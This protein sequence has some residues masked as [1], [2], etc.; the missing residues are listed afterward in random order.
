MSDK[1]EPEAEPLLFWDFQNTMSDRGVSVAVGIPSAAGAGCV[2][3]RLAIA[4]ERH[5]THT[6]IHSCRFIHSCSCSACSASARASWGI[7]LPLVERARS[8][9]FLMIATLALGENRTRGVGF[10]S[11]ENIRRTVSVT[12][13]SLAARF[14]RTAVSLGSGPGPFRY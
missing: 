5:D 13:S 2:G 6:A 7:S 10:T 4:A 12:A 11:G 9:R 8:A 3:G 14:G 1:T